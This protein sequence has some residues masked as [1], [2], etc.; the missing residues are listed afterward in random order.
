M[1]GSK[2]ITSEFSTK[3]LPKT[4][5]ACAVSEHMTETS[6]NT[7]TLLGRQQA[8]AIIGNQCSAA[9]AQC[10]KELH[11]SH[12]YQSYGLT[13]DQFCEQHTGISRSQA[14]RIISQLEEFGE[15]SSRL[16]QLTAISPAIY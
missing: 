14:D 1:R 7:A 2:L 10:L 5:H 8:Y 11:D 12:A 9:Q 15:N 3:L 16:S 6:S 13:W 4:A